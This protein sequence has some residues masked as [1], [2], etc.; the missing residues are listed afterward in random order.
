MPWNFVWYCFLQI[1]GVHKTEKPKKPAET[2]QTVAKILVWFWCGLVSVSMSHPN[3]PTRLKLNRNIL[4]INLYKL[5]QESS[6]YPSGKDTHIPTSQPGP[7]H[8]KSFF[9]YSLLI[10]KTTLFWVCFITLLI[11]FFNICLSLQQQ[12]VSPFPL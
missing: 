7:T 5:Y 11:L 8:N 3:I 1:R 4:N 12:L 6:W 9:I 2:N 10:T